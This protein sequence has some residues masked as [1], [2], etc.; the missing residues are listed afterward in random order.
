MNSH[1]S[2]PIAMHS[3]SLT[4]NSLPPETHFNRSTPAV[5]YDSAISRSRNNTAYS[6]ESNCCPSHASRTGDRRLI[7]CKVLSCSICGYGRSYT[8]TAC[9]SY[10][11]ICHNIQ[12]GF[13]MDC[14][15]CDKISRSIK[16]NIAACT[17]CCSGSDSCACGGS[18][19]RSG[20][21]GYAYSDCDRYSSSCD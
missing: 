17:A 4:R 2:C 5:R 15:A 13:R 7:R 8:I 21:C 12:E 19:S 9:N 20:S 3:D 10:I 14:A 18:G 11:V 1:T 6:A 16:C